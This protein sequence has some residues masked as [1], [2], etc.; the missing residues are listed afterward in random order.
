MLIP[1]YQIGSYIS[2][3]QWGERWVSATDEEHVQYVLQAMAEIHG[4]VVNEQ[5]TGNFDRR[6]WSLDPLAS[7]SW[8]SPLIGQ[9]ELYL[10]EYFKTHNNV[11]GG[12]S[13]P[14]PKNILSLTNK[15]L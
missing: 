12:T 7:G 5:F 14:G 4:E 15:L 6:C 1:A 3:G 11:R 8:A 13:A 2:G 10:P 9:H